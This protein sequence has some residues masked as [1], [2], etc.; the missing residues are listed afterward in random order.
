MPVTDPIADLLT[1]IRNANTAKKEKVEVPASKMKQAI[2][3]I[4]K[5]EGYIR[6]YRTV[7]ENGHN[8]LRIYL[9]YGPKGEKVIHLLER[10]SRPSVRR[11]V[12]KDNIP[13]VIGG[14]G[15]CILSTS[16]GLMTDREARAKGVGGEVLC[17]IW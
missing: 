14:L 3:D 7:E 4:L 2:V 11:Y 8:N 6:S 1:R 17:K 16:T 15:I 12:N 13:R 10:I 9:K 5:R